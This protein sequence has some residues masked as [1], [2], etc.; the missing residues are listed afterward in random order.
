MSK[1]FVIFLYLE[2][3]HKSDLF[4]ILD[5]EHSDSNSRL[6]GQALFNRK[7]AKLLISN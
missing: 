5:L 2:F 7:D 4:V 1:V 6:Y 3:V